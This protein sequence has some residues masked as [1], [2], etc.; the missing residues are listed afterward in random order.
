ME[1]KQF[2]KLMDEKIKL[3][4]TEYGLTQDKMAAILGISKKTLIEIEKNRK[5]LGWTNSIA[6]A[7]IFSDSTILHDAIGGDVSDIIIALAFKDIDVDYPKTWGGKVWWKTISEEKCYRIQQ[8]MFSRHYR[9]LDQE[10]R[11]IY[12]SFSLKEIEE[13]MEGILNS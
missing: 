3:I 13:I 6:L 7:S 5:S 10:N 1:K 8:N 12:A 9:L 4:R 2:V 11:R